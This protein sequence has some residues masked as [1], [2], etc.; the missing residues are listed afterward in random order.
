MILKNN[1]A[2]LNILIIQ[3]RL[4]K[5]YLLEITFLSAISIVSPHKMNLK[6]TKMNLN[7]A[8]INLITRKKMMAHR[9]TNPCKFKQNRISSEKIKE[10]N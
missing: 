2:I 9:I 8:I 5:L 7:K 4:H 3:Y 10:S 1:G 6:E